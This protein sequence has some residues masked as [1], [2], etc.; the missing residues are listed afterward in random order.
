MNEKETSELEANIEVTIAATH[1]VFASQDNNPVCQLLVNSLPTVNFIEG[2]HDFGRWVNHFEVTLSAPLEFYTNLAHN[3][4]DIRAAICS[5]LNDVHQVNDE[6][7]ADVRIKIDPQTI[8]DWRK[9]T[10]LLN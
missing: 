3:L 2:V 8:S 9:Q 6:I 5:V 1:A 10:G 4:K 7:V